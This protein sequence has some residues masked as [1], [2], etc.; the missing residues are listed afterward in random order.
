MVILLISNMHIHK[1]I[2]IYTVSFVGFEVLVFFFRF[3][4]GCIFLF[5]ALLNSHFLSPLLDFL[6]EVNS[7]MKQI[8]CS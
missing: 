5:K 7:F 4:I 8:R 3:Y 2:Y 6:G 1:K